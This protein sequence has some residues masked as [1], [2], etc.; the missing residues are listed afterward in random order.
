MKN[1]SAYLARIHRIDVLDSIDDPISHCDQ[2]EA[3]LD[4]LHEY[5]ALVSIIQYCTDM[6]PIIEAESLLHSHESRLEKLK[7][8]MITEPMTVNL[9][10]GTP[11]VC[12]NVPQPVST[13]NF[14]PS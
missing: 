11:T 2:L 12:E 10:Q 9:A 8:T 5:N 1:L 13:P 7:K 6:C 3:I 4:G 14:A